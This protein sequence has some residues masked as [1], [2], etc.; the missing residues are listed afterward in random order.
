MDKR[1]SHIGTPFWM[2][3][4]VIA[5]ESQY[6]MEY[7]YKADIWS[8]GITGI[9]LAD[10]VTP[11]HGEHPARVLF[12][13]PRD[14]PPS[15]KEPSR[16]SASYLDFLACCL[17]KDMD[18]RPGVLELLTHE[19]VD[20]THDPRVINRKLIRLIE[21][22]RG[23]RFDFEDGDSS[24]Q[25]LD[26]VKTETIKRSQAKLPADQVCDLAEL[27]AI[28]EG[29]MVH[30]IH[31]R[32]NKNLIYTYVGDV[33]I[34]INPFQIFDIYNP[35]NKR[36][37][38]NISHRRK[39]AP[40]IYAVSDFAYQSMLLNRTSQCCLISGESGAGKTEGSK[41][42]LQHLMTLGKAVSYEVEQKILKVNPVLEAF[43]NARTTINDNSSRFGKFIEVYFNKYGS[44]LGAEITQY[45]LEKSRLIHQSRRERSFHIFYYLL[46]FLTQQNKLK[47]FYFSEEQNEHR[48]LRV[49]G[50]KPEK[51]KIKSINTSHFEQIRHALDVIGFT[52][53]EKLSMY[54]IVSAI[55][56]MG[57]IQIEIDVRSL[58]NQSHI[59]ESTLVSNRDIAKKAGNLLRVD[60]DKLIEVITNML[61]FTHGEQIMI[62][63][64][65]EQ[66]MDIRDA[67]SK[68][69]YGR[70]FS[71]IV[72]KINASIVPR[73][74]PE[75]CLS[76]G[77]LDIFGFENFKKNSL[78]QLNINIANEQLQYFFNQHIFTLEQ[79]EYYKE[80]ISADH[81]TFINNQ[82]ILDMLMGWPHGMLS[83]LDDESK[84]S[85]ATDLSLV[86]K[87]HKQ[88]GKNKFYIQPKS[89]HPTFGVHHYAGRVNYSASGFLQKNRDTLQNSSVLLLRESRDPL[90]QELF[91]EHFVSDGS[92]MAGSLSK[93]KG[94][95]TNPQVISRREQVMTQNFGNKVQ[96]SSTPPASPSP[97]SLIRNQTVCTHF[98]HSLRDLMVK[99]ESAQPHFIRCIDPNGT[100]SPDVFIPHKV[101]EQLRY[102]G[103]LET[104]KIRK[105]GYS[106]R[107]LF[108]DFIERYKA[109]DLV[110]GQKINRAFANC[111]QILESAKIRGYQ[112]G[113]SKVFLRYY[114]I[115]QLNEIIKKYQKN[116]LIIQRYV[117]GF[118]A[119]SYKKR[120]IFNRRD[121]ASSV[122]GRNV[123]FW[124]LRVHMRR[125][126]AKET[127][128]I[129]LTQAA[130][131]GRLTRVWF[132]IMRLKHRREIKA[133]I[134]IQSRI[135][136]WLAKLR[137]SH[138]QENIIQ[139]NTLKLQAFFRG[140]LA[141]KQYKLL[142]NQHHAAQLIQRYYRVYRNKINL[143]RV[144]RVTKANSLIMSR[145][146]RAVNT[147]FNVWID[148]MLPSKRDQQYFTSRGQKEKQHFQGSL[149]RR[150][151]NKVLD[152]YKREMAA[153]TI[154]KYFRGRKVRRVTKVAFIRATNERRVVTNFLTEVTNICRRIHKKETQLIDKPWS[155]NN[156]IQ[157][158]SHISPI[159]HLDLTSAKE[160][161]T[162]F[163][164]L[165][166]SLG[167]K[168][169]KIPRPHLAGK[170][171]IQPTAAIL[172]AITSPTNEAVT[173][174]VEYNFNVTLDLKKAQFDFT[175]IYS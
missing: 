161:R 126:I 73:R 83:L 70:L 174:R 13:I 16:W 66:A 29:I 30:Y 165:E 23:P 162:Y 61:V 24:L 36:L 46:S 130:V 133:A 48:Y 93:G 34:S 85:S 150:L 154:Q 102:T 107:L 129:V 156:I 60:T 10:S 59:S 106:H 169:I 148:E 94:K 32:Y 100:K 17:V 68:A 121:K 98:R 7:D 91:S 37:Y 108:E 155:F 42:M 65:L 173:D 76:I 40:H 163:K 159:I 167:Q 112:L 22:S 28:D 141:R 71:W 6:D 35:K 55:L 90:I 43:G 45:L 143:E 115:E 101:L 18:K 54:S 11:Y 113:K 20:T 99:I 122:I 114:H 75:D 142:L 1:H 15:V 21:Q 128:C 131:R 82:P 147:D 79:A 31:E 97:T 9:E 134:K 105:Q 26:S 89:D 44:V 157:G 52:P 88:Y 127:R 3:P 138:L 117:R 135:R 137:F 118:L 2:A 152:E 69:L 62:P 119:R 4:E 111:A 80:G 103:V 104:C 116:A 38:S 53:N 110:Y 72:R 41:L 74:M 92:L 58:N 25:H 158:D 19:F 12:R 136:L 39:L 8:L 125:Y 57:D 27:E 5:C 81:I 86:T 144:Q 149:R 171:L 51:G 50:T 124:L 95:I 67:I 96:N 49:L 153:V 132:R 63:Y 164:N 172:P 77:L 78:E 47:D 166:Q 120:L 64:R 151:E 145:D 175:N 84:F 33:L 170:A 168:Q 160:S 56:H 109:I 139:E 140:C 146:P 14:P 87:F 123:R